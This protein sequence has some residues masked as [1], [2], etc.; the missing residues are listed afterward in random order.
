MNLPVFLYGPWLDPRLLK[1]IQPNSE[2]TLQNSILKGYELVSYGRA[3]TLRASEPNTIDGQLWTNCSAEALE[4]LALFETAHGKEPREIA[5]E[6]DNGT[7]MA[8]VYMCDHGSKESTWNSD[9][10]DLM[11]HAAEEIFDGAPLPSKERLHQSWPMIEKRAWA[12]VLAAKSAAPA[13]IRKRPKSGEIE[14]SSKSPRLGEFYRL[15]DTQLTHR[16]FDGATQGPL[17]REAFH[18]IDAALVLPYDPKTDRVLLIEQLRMGPLMRND[19]NPWALEPIAGMIDPGEMPPETARREAK[20]EAQ[21][22]LLDLQLINAN[23]PSP[24]SS[25]DFFYCF[26]GSCDLPDVGSYLGGLAEENEDLRAHVIS[27]DEAM[28][29]VCSGEIQTGPLIMML[30]WL[31]KERDDLR[32]IP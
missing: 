29:L 31:A 18:G 28:N 20:E 1:A 9:F 14:F 13:T 4:K 32:R 3:I 24:G 30:F 25:T 6:T 27:F 5:V 19:P 7:Q 8:Q 22:E 16:R 26:L 21:L 10:L 17:Q 15:Q 23:Y 2:P 11:V 12:K